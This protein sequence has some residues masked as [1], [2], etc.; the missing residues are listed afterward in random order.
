M[1]C[2]A[3]L[4]VFAKLEL[5]DLMDASKGKQ[6]LERMVAMLTKLARP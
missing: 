4:D 5:V 2:A 1:A 3:I 6:L